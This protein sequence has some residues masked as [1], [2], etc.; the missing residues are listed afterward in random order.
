M[1]YAKQDFYDGGTLFAAHLHHMEDGIDQN[2]SDIETAKSDIATAK[3][4]IE[5]LKNGLHRIDPDLNLLVLGD[6]IFGSY[7]GKAWLKTLN[8]NIQNYAVGGASIAEISEKLRIDGS[9][10]SL[11]DQFTRFKNGDAP[12]VFDEKNHIWKEQGSTNW[13]RS[14]DEP[15]AVLVCGGGNDYLSASH[16]GVLTATKHI[17]PAI[18]ADETYNKVVVA[19]ALHHLLRDIS[20][21]YPKAQRFFLI[22]HRAYQCNTDTLTDGKRKLWS[23]RQT[24]VRV[25]YT[26]TVDGKSVTTYELLFDQDENFIS[27]TSLDNVKTAIKAAKSLKVRE[28]NESKNANNDEY[29]DFSY[30]DFNA[31]SLY[32]SGVHPSGTIDEEKIVSSYTYETL[33]ETII[34]ICNMYGFKIIDIYN[35][36]PLNMIPSED[37]TLIEKVDDNG[38]SKWF[39]WNWDTNGGEGSY[40]STG[41]SSTT[42]LK[43]NPVKLANTRYLDWKGIHPT[44]LGYQIGYEPFI[45]QA[46]SFVTKK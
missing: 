36:S 5:D 22:M 42:T 39:Y 32:S 10:N 13:T 38:K 3:T 1:A 15:D 35:D 27:G 30:V 34:N 29:I 12:L 8:Y 28:F 26:R 24:Y 37:Q 6:S 18:Y 9:Y 19:G 41:V 25:P 4:D 33:R 43:S 14:F 45:K 23:V 11:I 7:D 31:D 46:L 20:T 40:R 17:V 2:A 21:T 16:L 44:V